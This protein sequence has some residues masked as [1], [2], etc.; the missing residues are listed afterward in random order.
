MKLLMLHN[1]YL[2]GGGEDQSTQEEAA[3]LREDGHE[4]QLLREDSRRIEQPGKMR[5]ALRTAWSK[6]LYHRIDKTLRGCGF[7]VMHVQNFFPLWAPAVYYAAIARP[8][9][10]TDLR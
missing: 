6:E 3:L 8:S 7:D 2:I 10:K 4:V 5:T 1:R 9:R